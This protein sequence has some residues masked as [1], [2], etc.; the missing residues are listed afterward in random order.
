[1]S[2]NAVPRWLQ[3]AR[4]IQAVSHTGLTY[5]SSDYEVQRYRRLTEIAAE[6]IQEHA[7]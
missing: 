1:M 7:S 6:I 2:E 3:W 5:A 4:E